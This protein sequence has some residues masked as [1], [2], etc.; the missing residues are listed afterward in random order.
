MNASLRQLVG[1]RS[2]LAEELEGYCEGLV[3]R[4][5]ATR[6]FREGRNI[7]GSDIA[8]PVRVVKESTRP[9]PKEGEK[10]G[11]AEEAPGSKAGRE[12]ARDYADPEVAELYEEPTREKRKEEV[13]WEQERAAVKRAVVQGGPG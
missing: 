8:V 6:W 13:A 7:L 2:R 9:E 1:V 5:D 10:G 12:P 3:A 4:L 11:G